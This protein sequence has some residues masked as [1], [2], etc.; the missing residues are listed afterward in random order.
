M[1]QPYRYKKKTI[2]SGGSVVVVIP[3]VNGWRG[4]KEVMI[5]VYKDRIVITKA[6]EK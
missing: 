2:K 5:E 1:E 6:K 4:T 3:A